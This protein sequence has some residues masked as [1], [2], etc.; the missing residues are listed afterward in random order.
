[1]AETPGQ[2]N[3]DGI[4]LASFTQPAAATRALAELL[5]AGVLNVEKE[6]V[7]DRVELLIEPDGRQAQVSAILARHGG[8]RV[9]LR[10]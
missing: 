4:V 5:E 8:V 9:P 3:V 7:G 2:S 1:M 6:T 10:G